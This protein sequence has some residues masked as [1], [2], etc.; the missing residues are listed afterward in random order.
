MNQSALGCMNLGH[1][2]LSAQIY[3]FIQKHLSH[4]LIILCK[5][6]G[7]RLNVR[8]EEVET[9]LAVIKKATDFIVSGI[10]ALRDS[11][12]GIRIDPFLR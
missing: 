6:K 5:Q 12:M 8:S 10:Y 3:I 2:R 7:Y 1:V 11:Q 9:G 4:I